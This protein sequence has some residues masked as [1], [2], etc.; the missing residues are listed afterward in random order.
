MNITTI[1]VTMI[2]MSIMMIAPFLSF[3]FRRNSNLLIIYYSVILIYQLVAFT[4]AYWFRTIGADMDA[5]SFH[6]LATEISNIGVFHF[7]SDANLYKNILGL[8]YWLTTPSLIIGE[9]L[10]ILAISI[11]III[12]ANIINLLRLDKFQTPIIFVYALLPTMFTLGAL[13]LREP[14][15]IFLLITATF[16]G[17]KMKIY[18]KMKLINF[19]LMLIFVIAA[20]LL[21][22]AIFLFG[23]IYVGAFM[24]WNIDTKLGKYKIT[25]S[26]LMLLIL[27]PIFLI[28]LFYFASNSSISGSELFRKILSLEILEA[29]SKHRSVTPIGRASY[30]IPFEAYSFSSLILSSVLI[31]ITYLFSPFLWQ[32]SSFVDFYAFIEAIIHLILIYYSIKLWRLSDGIT[33]SF[34]GLFLTLFFGMTFMWAL[35]TTNYGTGMRHKMISW[36]L[37]ALMGTPLLYSKILLTLNKLSFK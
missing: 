11:S 26:Q 18:P 16:F 8:L 32:V 33:R 14:L 25:K 15:Q 35:G 36:W 4:N 37:L 10:S 20:G 27:A 22:K 29:I 30:N 19:S 2:F 28:M 23:L 17:I 12:L 1:F 31:Y 3:H 34:L 6:V 13:T 24:I 21:H 5:N 9:Q 7:S